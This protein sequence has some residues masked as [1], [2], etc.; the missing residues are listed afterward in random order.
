MAKSSP[1]G[2][3]YRMGYSDSITKF[4][5]A[6]GAETEAFSLLPFLKPTDKLLDLG[7]GPGSITIGLAPQ[8]ASVTAIDLS[9]ISIDMTRKRIED[10]KTAGT[11]AVGDAAKINCLQADVLAG[12]PFPDNAFDVVY[13]SQIFVHLTGP[14]QA[15]SAMAEVRRVLKLGGILATR[16][17]AEALYYPR[18]LDMWENWGKKMN[19]ALLGHDT[20]FVADGKPVSPDVMPRLYRESG[21]DPSKTRISLG[22]PWLFAGRAGREFCIDNWSQKLDDPSLLDKWDAAGVTEEDKKRM[23]NIL[24]EWLENDD[25]YLMVT[26]CDILGWK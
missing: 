13:A 24:A 23:K 22:L 14:G 3:T 16:D 6:R 11:L 25:A 18:H 1:V 26:H 19:R 8:V 15:A 2:N 21:F 5:V 10:M 4:Q 12:L 7:C 20:R 9:G 17:A